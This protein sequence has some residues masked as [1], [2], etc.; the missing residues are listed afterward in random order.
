MT[1][2]SAPISFSGETEESLREKERRR[3]VANAEAEAR[4]EEQQRPLAEL[5]E[6]LGRLTRRLAELRGRHLALTNDL[7]PGG[8]LERAKTHAS[9]QAPGTAQQ[10]IDEARAELAAAELEIRALQA[11]AEDLKRSRPAVVRALSQQS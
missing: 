11:E 5:D 3:R 10:A 7:R 4:R 2:R 6:E 1:R 9:G 8:P